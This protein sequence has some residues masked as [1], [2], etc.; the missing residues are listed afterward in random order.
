[1]SATGDASGIVIT[2][3]A[4]IQNKYVNNDYTLLGVGGPSSGLSHGV[5]IQGNASQTPRL[6]TS[7]GGQLGFWVPE[8]A[9]A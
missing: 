2:N 1:M 5:V 4:V 3:N 7:N 8:M 6:R 9:L